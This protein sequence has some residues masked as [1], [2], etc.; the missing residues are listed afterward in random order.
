[1]PIIITFTEGD[2]LATT[3]L[4]D[5][6]G[7]LVRSHIPRAGHGAHPV[8]KSLLKIQHDLSRVIERA[9]FTHHELAR[10][11]RRLVQYALD[12]LADVLFMVVRNHPYADQ[13]VGGE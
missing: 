10:K 1:M 3:G 2:I 13:G 8:G 5:S 9:I 11:R 6:T 12:S 7:V 4:H